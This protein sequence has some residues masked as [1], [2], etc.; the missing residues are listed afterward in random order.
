MCARFKAG[1]GNRC[2][3][4]SETSEAAVCLGIGDRTSGDDASYPGDDLNA[5]LRSGKWIFSH[6][7]GFPY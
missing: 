5:Q 3:P 2:H 6:Q 7:D 4:V 1:T